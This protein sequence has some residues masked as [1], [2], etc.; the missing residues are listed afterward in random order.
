MSHFA[1]QD[2]L[3]LLLKDYFSIQLDKTNTYSLLQLRALRWCIENVIPLEVSNVNTNEKYEVVKYEDL[4]A[5]IKEYYNLCQKFNIDYDKD[6]E[7]MYRQPSSKAHKLGSI[8]SQSPKKNV[9]NAEELKQI[10]SI[11]NIFETK[12]YPIVG[13]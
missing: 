1:G 7:N 12:L 6:V 4:V 10:N 2:Q 5:D 3:V 8:S 13:D 11:L 9:F